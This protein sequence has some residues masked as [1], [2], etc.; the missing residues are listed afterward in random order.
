M[1][2]LIQNVEDHGRMIALFP[3]RRRHVARAVRLI[4]STAGGLSAFL[5][6]RQGAMHWRLRDDEDTTASIFSAC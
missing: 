6:Y 1:D 4:D 5:W 3:L 2:C